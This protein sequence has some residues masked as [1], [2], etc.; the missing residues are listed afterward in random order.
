MDKR[1]FLKLF[2]LF[3]IF[4]Y[5]TLRV[6]CVPCK[7]M[8]RCQCEENES[9]VKCDNMIGLSVL[10]GITP[11]VV[12]LT[13]K[14]SFLGPTLNTSFSAYIMEVEELDLSSSRI[15]TITIHVFK[16]LRNLRKLNL[17]NNFLRILKFE[18]FEHLN[19]LEELDLSFNRFEILPDRPFY[20]LTNLRMLNISFNSLINLKLGLR[21]QVMERMAMLDFS[22]NKFQTIFED[23]FE[24][25]ESWLEYIPKKI[26]LSNCGIIYIESG[27]FRNPKSLTTLVLNGNT[28][29]SLGNLT[30]LFNSTDSPDIRY[31]D[32]SNTSLT[33]VSGLFLSMRRRNI[34]ELNLSH[35]NITNLSSELSEN[36]AGTL[37]KFVVSHNMLTSLSPAVTE[38]RK[39]WYLDLSFNHISEVDPNLD[40]NLINLKEFNL[41]HNEI[42]VGLF[43]LQAFRELENLDLSFN[44]LTTYI[45]PDTL[46]KLRE[47]NLAGNG[48]SSLGSLDRL[49]NLETFNFQQN[50]LTELDKFLFVDSPNI[51]EVNFSGNNIEK[52]EDF[53]F[54][55]HSPKHI[56]LSNN[57]LKKLKFPGW[58]NVETLNLKGNGLESIDGEAFYALFQLKYLDLAENNLVIFEDNTFVYL[59]NLT[60]LHLE[61]NQLLDLSNW[62]RLFRSLSLLK[63][64]DL[65]YNNLNHFKS[66][67]FSMC[68][69]LQYINVSYNRI[70]YVEPSALKVMKKL[71]KVDFSGNRFKCDC[72]LIEFRD[73]I[74]N[75][76]VE[77]VNRENGNYTC[78][79]PSHQNGKD[80]GEF[81]VDEFECDFMFLYI[82]VYSTVGGIFVVVVVTTAFVCHYHLK[83]RKNLLN[84]DV[85]PSID[86]ESME[87]S[88]FIPDTIHRGHKKKNEHLH[89][90][91][92]MD[93]EYLKVKK[94]KTKEN[95]EAYIMN[96]N[97]K[98]LQ[99]G[100]SPNGME[101][102][103][104]RNKSSSK[105]AKNRQ[106]KRHR[107]VDNSYWF[108]HQ[109][110]LTIPKPSRRSNLELNPYVQQY[111]WQQ[112]RKQQKNLINRR[113]NRESFRN[114]DIIRPVQGSRSSPDF[115]YMAM[116]T[117]PRS[118]NPVDHRLN[119]HLPE[120]GTWHGSRGRQNLH[121]SFVDLHQLD[122]IDNKHKMV[123]SGYNTISGVPSHR[124]QSHYI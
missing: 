109:N 6:D 55:P 107:N 18:V 102:G 59:T 19:A 103:K 4:D 2:S 114:V 124:S 116:N 46:E 5:W 11:D 7:T 99:N 34:E 22:G 76:G 83:W 95:A 30:N 81:E 43:T 58:Q 70:Y 85:A 33:D 50:K 39:L 93:N 98:L 123:M 120:M 77:I 115:R 57:R 45:I 28:G 3:L 110:E 119:E 87:H 101:N 8:L 74:Y 17:R 41:G 42:S 90:N 44:K 13:I 37:C 20:S 71:S 31:V 64:L 113:M 67:I 9:I 75:T 54:D 89:M 1:L 40:T 35:N 91:T 14:N 82:V 79:A 108:R 112:H 21:F 104:I 121:N 56:D 73:W 26:N 111:L 105:N 78:I 12:S 65:S 96:G 16:Y 25:T 24:M 69:S 92:K 86:F 36:L 84:S 38:L 48:I 80:V 88:P 23:S 51:K 122:N 72:D 27:A 15:H 52:L 10:S 29:I 49:I 61:H 62:E 94:R 53:V 60:S 66:S 63:N 32:L 118:R 100:K 117:L 106:K 47:V 97:A 68:K